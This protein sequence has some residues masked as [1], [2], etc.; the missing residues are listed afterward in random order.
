[1]ED[2]AIRSAVTAKAYRNSFTIFSFVMK[3]Y[4]EQRNSAA[5]V[6]Q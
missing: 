4:R 5:A 1:M 2:D 3:T 6:S